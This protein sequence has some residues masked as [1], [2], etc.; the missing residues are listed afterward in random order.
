MACGVQ[1]ILPR[2]LLLGRDFLARVTAPEKGR[3]GLVG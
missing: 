2:R 1:L 3:L